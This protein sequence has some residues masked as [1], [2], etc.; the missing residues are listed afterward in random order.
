MKYKNLMSLNQALLSL[1]LKG[2][3]FARSVAKNINLLKP[4]IE[5]L[6]KAIEPDKGF[7]EF[8]KER[9]KLAKKYAQKDEKGQPVVVNNSFQISDQDAFDKEFEVLKNENQ[10]VCEDREKQVKDFQELLEEDVRIEL[11]KIKFTEIP[12]DI[13]TQQYVSIMDL[14]EE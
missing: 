11:Y 4:D 13:S 1:N 10:K 5:S 9:V 3:K 2:V 6:S 8:D 7:L 12:E 14:I